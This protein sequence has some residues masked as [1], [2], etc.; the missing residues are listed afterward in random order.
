MR[1]PEKCTCTWQG[2]TGDA[3]TA[4]EITQ[5]LTGAEFQSQVENQ[6]S[7]GEIKWSEVWASIYPLDPPESE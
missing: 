6:L 5:T 4:E 3:D 1:A 7:G 2:E